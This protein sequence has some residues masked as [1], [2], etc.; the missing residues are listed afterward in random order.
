MGTEIFH[1]AIFFYFVT[2]IASLFRILIRNDISAPARVTWF[3]IIIVIPYVG[4]LIYI[5][6][7]EKK[8]AKK[9]ETASK[10]I[11]DE[12][13][14]R[15]DQLANV[16][17]DVETNINPQYQNLFNCAKS[18]NGF[19]PVIGNKAELMQDA[20]SA[21]DSIIKDINQAQ[22][23]IHIMYYIWLDDV[24]GKR[25]AV[26]IAEAAK[27]GVQCK[28][29]VDGLGSRAFLKTDTCK[30][31]QESGVSFA[32]ALPINHP[33]MTVLTSRIDLR[34]HRK[35]T[36]I[37]G[38]VT[39]CGSRNCADPEFRVKRKYAPWV[40][41]LLR[42]EGPVVHQMELLF[43]TDWKLATNQDL[44]ESEVHPKPLGGGF[45]ANAVGDGPVRQKNSTSQLI[46]SAIESAK[47]EI[48]I[49]TP[50][51]VPDM[52]VLG[53][54]KSAGYRGVA[55][56]LI[57]PMHNDSWI[58]SA[59]S[60]SYYKTLLESSCKI[61]EYRLGL[62]HAKT[63]TIDGEVL[64]VG[65]T[66]LDIRSFDLN[67]ENDILLQDKKVTQDVKA[68]QHQYMADSVQISLE[69]VVQWS[70]FK[71]IWNNAVATVGPIL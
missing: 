13:R 53:V 10:R 47:K 68:R 33:I 50:Y 22:N 58:V 41:I 67:F 36:V 27:R 23:Y 54:L 38:L 65:S 32:V 12:I 9:T 34:N 25:V 11:W 19:G 37:D 52:N 15:K 51:F 21:V 39:Y 42:F 20:E 17:A 16:Y 43:Q 64:F 55:V 7:G 28:I 14:S 56:T 63:L 45:V 60:K 35:I 61:Y 59:A 57:F 48:I 40:D 66:N 2:V 70:A 3:L 8:L 69:D 29:M 31:M 44:S 1:L 24:T 71:Q 26:A 4:L 30:K 49:S 62:L 6:F 18:M 5:L 46:V